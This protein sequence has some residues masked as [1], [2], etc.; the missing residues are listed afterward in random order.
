MEHYYISSTKYT[1]LER[2]TKRYGKVYDVAFRVL[3]LDGKEIQ[4]RLCGYETKTAAKEAYTKFVTE[5]IK[6]KAAGKTVPC[7]RRALQRVSFV[8]AQS[9]QRFHHLLKAKGI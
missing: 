7:F 3:S 1:L 4:K 2:Q 6:E 8:A 5:P 9:G